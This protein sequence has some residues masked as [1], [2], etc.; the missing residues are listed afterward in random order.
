MP[1]KTN[2]AVGRLRDDKGRFV[3]ESSS[4]S[5][6]ART[7]SSVPCVGRPSVNDSGVTDLYRAETSVL[8]PTR[9]GARPAAI[10]PL[11][12][13]SSSHS[14]EAAFL[15][16]DES[17]DVDLASVAQGVSAREGSSE[18]LVSV[19]VDLASG[20]LRVSARGGSSVSLDSQTAGDREYVP[21]VAVLIH[22]EVEDP[23]DVM[24]RPQ[25]KFHEPPKF[26]G[27]PDEDALDW[28]TR[29]ETTGIYNRWAAEDPRTHFVMSLDGAALK[30]Y[31]CADL[32]ITWDDVPAQR[33]ANAEDDVEATLGLRSFFL[34]EFQ[35]EN[36]AFFKEK[37][38][39][40]EFRGQR[41]CRD[42]HG[43]LL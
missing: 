38:Y 37:S 41:T 9:V 42:L 27:H 34:R 11:S 18:S 13:D 28:L 36:Y 19:D 23:E 16:S 12:Q 1:P 35:Q 26:W 3:A 22:P 15:S 10:D 30:W 21:S 43:V 2:S 4:P 32:P 17:E 6:A 31:R 20:A 5:T 7:R 8:T 25:L 39:G 24:A 29:Y 40:P 14:S 33:G